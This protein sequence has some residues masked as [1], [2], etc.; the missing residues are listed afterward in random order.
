VSTAVMIHVKVF[1]TDNIQ[2]TKL[3][4]PRLDT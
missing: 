3:M 1:Y 4:H 2:I